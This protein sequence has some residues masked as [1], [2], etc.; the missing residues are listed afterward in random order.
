MYR[1]ELFPTCRILGIYRHASRCF[2]PQRITA[3]AGVTSAGDGL[4]SD[5]TNPWLEFGALQGAGS[6]HYVP[7]KNTF[8]S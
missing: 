4:V 2:L 7:Q 6:T 8:R 5:A 3:A 1:H